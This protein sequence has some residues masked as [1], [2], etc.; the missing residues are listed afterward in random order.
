VTILNSATLDVVVAH[1]MMIEDKVKKEVY[2]P[3]HL[4]PSLFKVF[5]RTLSGTLTTVWNQSC[6]A[7]GMATGP[8]L[9]NFDLAKKE[10]IAAHATEQDWNELVQ[11]LIH[12]VKPRS[13]GVQA[14][15]HHLFE[16]NEA[17]VLLPG[18]A[19]ALTAQQVKQVFFDQN[20]LSRGITSVIIMSLQH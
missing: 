2:L 6:T 1:F 10:F 17:V 7:I 11:Q 12:P 3:V 8:T 16:L 13:L 20:A 14:F 18:E 15:L 9:E 19:A 4:G 5:P